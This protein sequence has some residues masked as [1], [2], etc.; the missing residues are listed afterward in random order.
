MI[1]R[2]QRDALRAHAD[3]GDY[4]APHEARKA[5][6]VRLTTNAYKHWNETR[7]RLIAQ[8]WA[9]I[10]QFSVKMYRH[11]PDPAVVA[12][13]VRARSWY[14]HSVLSAFWK[15]CAPITPGGCVPEEVALL[16]AEA[17]DLGEGDHSHC[18]SSA[19]PCS[20]R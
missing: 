20:G 2:H 18:T 5:S 13:F 4:I 3:D 6:W 1:G 17:H 12:E 16:L 11:E 9:P 7:D 14:R 19:L 8:A 15:F 10:E